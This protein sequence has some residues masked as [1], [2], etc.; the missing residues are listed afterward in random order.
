VQGVASSNPA[1]PT[2]EST[3]QFR[4]GLTRFSFS[5]PSKRGWPQ[6]SAG[7]AHR[8]GQVTGNPVAP[9]PSRTG[10]HGAFDVPFDLSRIDAEQVDARRSLR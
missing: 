7:M 1:T 10:R 3:G 8:R 5:G 2:N 4:K 9:R 6:R